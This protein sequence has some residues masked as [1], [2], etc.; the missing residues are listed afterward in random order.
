MI[1]I[2]QW[3]VWGVSTFTW[4][5]ANSFNSRSKNTSSALYCWVTTLAVSGF[6]LT[7]MLLVGNILVQSRSQAHDFVIAVGLYS[8]LSACGSVIGQ[9]LALR[10]EHWKHI[11]HE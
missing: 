7:S 3:I 10:F 6:Y 1:G 11:A 5:G 8:V 9:Q 2:T 4:N